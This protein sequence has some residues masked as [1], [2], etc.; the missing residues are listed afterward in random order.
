MTGGILLLI[1]LAAAAIAYVS[2]RVGQFMKYG[3]KMLV[4]CPET[5][6]PAAVKVSL[7]RAIVAAVVGQR[8]IEL[9]DCSRWPER[10]GCPQDCLCQIEADPE[11]HR[12]WQIAS[13]WYEGKTCVYC[14]KP[15][16]KFDHLD[17]KPALLSPEG[18]TFEWNTIPA[19][20]LPEAMWGCLP[21]CWNCH[22]AETFLREHPDRV[23]MRPWERGG[24]VGEYVPKKHEEEHAP[25]PK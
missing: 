15:I 19:E 13:K 17:R 25:A 8:H 22:I 10:E 5:G 4:T 24:P 1:A 18:K 3:G 11:G 20:K 6:K 9:S 12:V 7:W 21:V 2:Y 23:T 16:E 14:K